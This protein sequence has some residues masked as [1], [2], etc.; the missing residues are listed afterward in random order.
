MNK[1]FENTIN[2]LNELF[3]KVCD[4]EFVTEI[5]HL[6][7][8]PHIAYRYTGMAKNR[9]FMAIADGEGHLMVGIQQGVTFATDNFKSHEKMLK[10]ANEL[11]VHKKKPIEGKC[12]A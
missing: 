8:E 3:V 4:N 9:I 10:D 12:D 1:I 7:T 11:F 5:I 6:K 2:E